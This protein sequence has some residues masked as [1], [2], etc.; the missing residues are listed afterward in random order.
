MLVYF[1]FCSENSIQAMF[2]VLQ[3]TVQS[4]SFS[5]FLELLCGK[6]VSSIIC[7]KH[8]CIMTLHYEAVIFFQT[9]GICTSK[10]R[11]VTNGRCYRLH[12]DMQKKRYVLADVSESV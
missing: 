3:Y 9:F 5:I 10:I 8:K 2:T 7:V 12:I 11:D 6:N 4:L 1:Q